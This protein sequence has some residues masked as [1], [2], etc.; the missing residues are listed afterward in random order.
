MSLVDKRLED[1]KQKLVDLSKR[2]KLLYFN[3]PSKS[4]MQVNHPS[5]EKVFSRLVVDE[6]PF[7]FYLPEIEAEGGIHAASNPKPGIGVAEQ[8]GIPESVP[9]RPPRPDELVA[10]DKEPEVLRLVLRNLFRRSRSDYEDRGVRVLHLAFGLIEWKEP[11]MTDSYISPLILVPVE[12]DRISVK[13]PFQLKPTDDEIVLNPALQVK[14]KNDFKLELPELPDDWEN[15]SLES[16]LEKVSNKIKRLGWA[17]RSEC[18][19][20]MF[21]FHKLVMYQDLVS[22]AEIIKTHPIIRG[23]AGEK[24]REVR[25]A[26]SGELPSADK[27]DTIVDPRKSHLVVEA[28]S[29]QMACMEAAKKGL[30]LVIHGPPG[31]GKS[32]TIT[33]LIAESVAEG[34][35]VLFVSEKM[36]ALEVVHKRLKGA[37]LG[38]FCLELHSHKANKRELV[39]ELAKCYQETLEPTADLSPQEFQRLLS[40]R[41]KLNEYVRALHVNRD[42]LMKS[43]FDVFGELARLH[44][45]SVVPDIRLELTAVTPEFIDA[46][47]DLAQRLS[48]VWKIAEEENKFIWAGCTATSFNPELRAQL[49]RLLSECQQSVEEVVASLQS[50]SNQLDLQTPIDIQG[51]LWLVQ[52]IKHLNEGPLLGAPLLEI[53]DLD[54]VARGVKELRRLVADR[55]SILERLREKY[56]DSFFASD[57][58]WSAELI[59]NG[60]QFLTLLPTFDPSD[61]QLEDKLRSVSAWSIEF[62]K[63]LPGW[64]TLSKLCEDRLRL[65][66]AKNPNALGELIQIVN[67]CGTGSQPEQAWFTQDTFDRASSFVAAMRASFTKRTELRNRLLPVYNESFLRLVGD[68]PD[69]QAAQ[70]DLQPMIGSDSAALEIACDSHSVR[71]SRE[72]IDRLAGVLDEAR[73]ISE[74]L[75]IRVPTTLADVSA[76]ATLLTLLRSPERP[77]SMWLATISPGDVRDRIRDLRRDIKRRKDLLSDISAIFDESH[78]GWAQDLDALWSGL[79]SFGALVQ[80]RPQAGDEVVTKAED[81]YPLFSALTARTTHVA[82]DAKQLAAEL[83]WPEPTTMKEIEKLVRIASIAGANDRPYEGWLDGSNRE[84]AKRALRDL[85]VLLG[86]QHRVRQAVVSEFE[87][88]VLELEVNGMI[89]AL[90][91][92]YDSPLKWLQPEYHRLRKVVKQHRRDGKLPDNMI[93]S[94]RQVQDVLDYELKLK[95]LFPRIKALVGHWCSDRETDI[96]GARR[97]IAFVEELE[98]VGGTVHSSFVQLVVTSKA[99][100]SA[101]MDVLE[102]LKAGV[103]DWFRLCEQ[104]GQIISFARLPATGLPPGESSLLSIMTWL[105]DIDLSL[106]PVVG[107]L[108]RIRKSLRPPG[109]FNTNHIYLVLDKIREVLALEARQKSLED[110]YGRVLGHW[111]QGFDTDVESAE[112]ALEV[113][114]RICVLLNHQV[115]DAVRTLFS[116]GDDG[117]WLTADVIH[118][119]ETQVTF[120]RSGLSRLAESFPSGIFPQISEQFNETAIPRHME[121]CKNFA[122]LSGRLVSFA[123]SALAAMHSPSQ[124]SVGEQLHDLTLAAELLYLEQHIE[125]RFPDYS[126]ALG[127][128]FKGYETDLD[129]AEQGLKLVLILKQKVG[130]EIPDPL[131]QAVCSDLPATHEVLT[132]ARKAEASIAHLRSLTTQCLAPIQQLGSLNVDVFDADFD[133]STKW[134][135]QLRSIVFELLNGLEQLTPMSNAGKFGTLT[136]VFHDLEYLSKSR[137]LERRVVQDQVEWHSW[138]PEDYQGVSTDWD[139]IVKNVGWL[140]DLRSSLGSSPF[141]TLV[142]QLITRSSRHLPDAERIAEYIIRF[143]SLIDS[144]SSHFR[145]A[146]ARSRNRF[147]DTQRRPFPEWAEHFVTLATEIDRLS[148]WI[149]YKNIKADLKTQGLEKLLDGLTGES[150]L[151]ASS[152]PGVVYKT[153]LSTWLA[154]AFESDPAL[155]Q[156]QGRN[157]EAVIAEFRQLDRKL[158]DCGS[159]RVITALNQRRS[160]LPAV[161]PGGEVSTLL[162]EAA[163]KKKHLP[164][165]RLIREIPNLLT[166]LK[167]C[168][169]MSPLS[170]SQFLDPEHIKFDLIIFDEASQICSEDAVGAIYRGQQVVICGDNK[171]LPPTSFFER[172]SQDDDF[173]EEN[174]DDF[175]VFDSILDECIALGMPQSWLRWHYRSKHESL[176]AFS[177]HRFYS[178]RLVVFPSAFQEHELLGVKLVHVPDGVY[179]RGGNRSNPREAEVVARIVIDHWQRYPT[180]SIAVIAFSKAQQETIEDKIERL[181][182]D[183]P[184]LEGRYMSA[185]LE[186][187]FVKNLESAQG[188]ER[189]VI[190][191]SVGYGKDKSGKLTMHFG[192]L[193]AQGGERRL[194]VAVTRAREQVVL[195]SSIRAADMDVSSTKAAGVLNLYHY[196]DYADRG[197][198]ALDLTHPM[199]RGDYDSPLEEDVAACIREMGFDVIPQVGCAGYRIDLGVIAPEQPG[200]FILGIECDGAMYHSSHTARDR[201]RMRQ[202]V[203]EGKGWAIH[204]IWSPEWVNRRGAEIDRLR[205]A[206]EQARDHSPRIPVI[207]VGQGAEP[208]V[209]SAP[210]VTARKTDNQIVAAEDSL[211]AWV[212]CYETTEFTSDILQGFDMADA[213]SA[214]TLVKLTKE[215]IKAEAPIHVKLLSR[216]IADYWGHQRISPKR[217]EAVEAAVDRVCSQGFAEVR[218]EFIYS[219]FK[220]AEILVRCPDPD[221]PG[222]QRTID[223]IPPEELEGAICFLVQDCLSIDEDM[224]ARRV[225]NIF[226]FD[227]TGG[228]IREAIDAALEELAASGGIVK[229]GNRVS[230]PKA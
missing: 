195:V 124:R 130:P 155:G 209:L 47:K 43:A 153:I 80:L 51:A 28:D 110:T 152:I 50:A 54:T 121:H 66:S 136:E 144:L 26:L 76:L 37:H 191:F 159:S 221:E 177:N 82:Q 117:V 46:T 181:L 173:F 176:I 204:R 163:K 108:A 140:K 83:A 142:A 70:R 57:P 143:E 149:D 224:L 96:D 7:K 205:S 2:N 111:Y 146:P 69:I 217:Q 59:G 1:W 113:S 94:L 183:H 67:L 168:I 8:R 53:V 97:C 10:K 150:G 58:S 206:I 139:K 178:N 49:L 208:V 4:S 21:S 34:K 55:N 115:P 86:E 175:P 230:R 227:R 137:E 220:G 31:T 215:V 104:I 223:L 126:T 165:R 114:E 109:Q 39:Q 222:T 196:L 63:E 218:D 68:L 207:G 85:E 172:E 25:D 194:N 56:Q 182:D 17:V 84:L 148:D 40:R 90:R 65:A 216:R 193:N 213:V 219:N 60:K 189:D 48:R 42:P 184:E 11:N 186:G 229:A 93:E 120:I 52:V 160:L 134:L 151:E 87:A 106:A 30:N 180:R 78:R 225:A 79:D 27:L 138:F 75:R 22:R 15:A 164:I 71:T 73:S 16:Y 5:M 41:Q 185:G 9:R 158:I 129:D 6:K 197:M 64:I 202:Q 20:G 133:V 226:G 35:S 122:D 18:W 127:R 192:P 128:C 14:L 81:L 198:V 95:E 118:R 187:F 92:Q 103:A 123:Q 166:T 132:L 89:K 72:V 33:N 228:L 88:G 179:D 45:C 162:R 105:R 141:P 135:E 147:S 13:A 190:I 101:Q 212:M 201:D 157:H 61:A 116:S 200:K 214:E 174:D 38:H 102:R 119:L 112:R 19:L 74:R 169:L 99:T 44:N 3:A 203:L 100:I 24:T 211:P 91:T 12:L 107:I 154:R 32:Q 210:K 167:P 199:G 170:V 171:Q 62:L 36:A 161:E 98:V 131:V 77:V 156:F 23:L 145:G 188:D 125:S 29:S